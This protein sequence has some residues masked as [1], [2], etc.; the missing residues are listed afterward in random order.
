MRRPAAAVDE[1][2]RL[3]AALAHLGQGVAG[4]LVQRAG[5]AVATA[6][7]EQL[8][9]RQCAAVDPARQFD[10]LQRVPALGARRRRAEDE[11]GARLGGAAPG[12]LA[13]VVARVTLLLV[14]AVVLLV[15]DDQPQA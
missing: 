2:D 13:G 3:A 8:N 5:A 15:D 11:R 9:R 12:D 10:P 6:H 1:H 4:S 14:G 7:V